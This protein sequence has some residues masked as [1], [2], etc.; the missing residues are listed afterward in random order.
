VGSAMMVEDQ[1]M[2]DDTAN[3]TTTARTFLSPLFPV[4]E[5]LAL[6]I[7]VAIMPLFEIKDIPI[8]VLPEKVRHI[9]LD[10]LRRQ[11]QRLAEAGPPMILD[12]STPRLSDKEWADQVDK[13][14]L[15]DFVEEGYRHPRTKN[16]DRWE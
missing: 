1:T 16:E 12:Q 4:N 5:L 11:H 7:T 9:V 10:A 2:N 14:N 15:S 8:N 3:K 13:M 6:E